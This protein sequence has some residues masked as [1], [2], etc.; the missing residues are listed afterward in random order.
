MAVDS[1][2]FEE[3]IDIFSENKSVKLLSLDCFDTLFWRKVDKPHDVFS[4]INKDQGPSPRA[5]AEDRA[6]AKALFKKKTSEVKIFDIYKEMSKYFTAYEI[7]RRIKEEIEAEIKFG[8]IFQPAL[9]LLKIAKAKGIRVIIVS[10]I[11][12]SGNQ[13]GHII[14]SVSPEAFSLIDEIYTSSD[15]GH[16]KTSGLWNY[17]VK[18]E[19]INAKNI[20]HVG[21]NINA[22]FKTPAK[23]GISAIHFR[24]NEKVIMHIMEQR[25]VASSLLFSDYQNVKAIPSLF[26]SWYSS[27][28]RDDLTAEKTLGVTVLGPALFAFCR[29]IKKQ[30]A[31]HPNIKLAFLMR[32]GYMPKQAY[33]AMY[34][35]ENTY[36]LRISRLT[37]ICSSFR[38]KKDV[39]DYLIKMLSPFLTN[40]SSLKDNDELVNII[41]KHLLL[42]DKIK[43]RIKYKLQ[44]S[45]F[46][47]Y[48]FIEILLSENLVNEVINN[49]AEYRRR[50]I[51]HIKRELELKAGD[52]L[53]LIDLGYEGTTQNR[54]GNIL[55][56]ELGVYIVGCYLI[57]AHTP[58][59]ERKRTGL[60]TPVDYDWRVILSLT[61]HIAS[62]ELLCSSNDNSVIDYDLLGDPVYELNDM[63]QSML[64]KVRKIQSHAINFIEKNSDNITLLSEEE[65]VFSESVVSDIARFIYFPTLEETLFFESLT[66]DVNLGTKNKVS[67]LDRNKSIDYVSKYGISRLVDN[68]DFRTNYP[69]ELRYLGIDFSISLLT[70]YRNS[71]EFSAADSV[72]RRHKIDVLFIYGNETLLQSIESRYTFDGFYSFYIPVLTTEFIVMIGRVSSIMEVIDFSIVQDKYLFTKREVDESIELSYNV[73]Y[74]IDGGDMNGSIISN[75]RDD[76]FIYIRLD[77]SNKNKTIRLTYRI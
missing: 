39:E 64:D 40:K 33:N 42:S 16:G 12:L 6:R 52:T 54:L 66:F 32:D 3:I 30:S 53:M 58:D 20:F 76:G 37:S 15:I 28:A 27:Y 21:D 72:Q 10:D 17:I 31:N 23:I 35:L 57:V 2:S 55:E 26:H 38:C 45:G 34:P 36:S 44:R 73:N 41:L 59:W 14:K 13:L 1:F 65:K 67:F 47:I 60:I 62:F 9:C 7:E 8:F 68:G 18:K 75:L 70:S 22:D 4:V 43:D 5:K 11:Y 69:S 61:N 49:S 77:E 25:R 19:K 24:Q 63:P 74:T 71:I 29:H 50:L 56:K 46:S 48:F 51:L